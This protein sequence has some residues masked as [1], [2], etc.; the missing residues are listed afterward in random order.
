MPQNERQKN[1]RV[2]ER[3][4]RVFE[5]LIRSVNKGPLIKKQA[6]EK[7]PPIMPQGLRGLGFGLPSPSP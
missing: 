3:K 6:L 5:K 2:S 4:Q 1:L 7:R